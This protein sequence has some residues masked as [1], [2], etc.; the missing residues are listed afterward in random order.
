MGVTLRDE[1]LGDALGRAYLLARSNVALPP[2]WLR[3]AEQLG[4]SPSVAFVAAI[5]AALLAK[6]ADARVDSFVIQKK[7]GSPG[8][9][10]LRKAAT[11]LGQ[12][13]RAYGYDIGS[14]SERDPINHGTLIGSKRWDDA[15]ER[16]RDG[17][18]PF[19]E[20]ILTWLPDINAMDE[21]EATS[22]LAAFIR[23]RREVGHRDAV[24]A[25]PPA[26]D[27][28]P[29]LTS[30][31]EALDG[32]V[33]RDPERGARGM[34]LVAAVYR[35]AGFE[36][37]LPSPNDPRRIDIPIRR[38]GGLV[39]GA[40][41]K[42]QP[43]GEGVA[44]SLVDDVLAQG[45]D[46]ALLAVLRPGCLDGF[47]ETAAIRRAERRGVVLRI[48]DNVRELL[49]E[50]LSAGNVSVSDFSTELPRAYAEALSEVGAREESIETWGAIV[51]GRWMR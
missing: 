46:R 24:E 26:L 27:Q 1:D 32:F 40:E 36:A 41:V 42:Q 28:D 13:R 33:S 14:S 2:T 12:K 17:H 22:A 21:D 7:E 9:Y 16:I 19:F 20:V 4:D 11:V 5:G 31:V 49:H 30:L 50:A 34:A 8:A 18:K 44:D 6:A 25:V 47:D 38:E 10:S 29:G 35:V 48:T 3:R 23:V 45:L 37:G 51:A 15:L 39:I 43:T